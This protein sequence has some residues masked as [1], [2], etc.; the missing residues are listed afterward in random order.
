MARTLTG[1]S[2]R[3]EQR[4]QSLMLD[5][6]VAKYDRR[7][8][9]EIRVTM[10]KAAQAVANGRE[11][12][13]VPLMDLHKDRLGRIFE[14]LWRA[15]AKDFIEHTGARVKSMRFEKKE[16][17]DAAI[18]ADAVDISVPQLVNRVMTE[19]VIA[20]GLQRITDIAET[21]RSDI[22]ALTTRGIAEGLTEREVASLIYDLAPTKSRS[23]SQTI[24]RT[25]THY[26]ANAG[27]QETAQATGVEMQ[28]E[29]VASLDERTR[30]NH[31][32]A[33][34]QTVGMNEPFIVGNAQLMYPGDQS[35]GAPSE[36]INCRCAVV[37]VPVI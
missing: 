34:G 23:R 10:R 1:N 30:D 36:T 2:R 29:W 4:L 31:V 5:R 25:E 11:G 9:K 15:S 19:I 22:G 16:R 35:A 14:S 18:L 27:A 7:I 12:Q 28:R 17:L 20:N 32:V 24:A 3:R 6:L 26:A 33:D 37:F 8:A 13:I 21:T